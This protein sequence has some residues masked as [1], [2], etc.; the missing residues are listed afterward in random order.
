MTDK[1]LKQ[2]KSQLPEDERFDRAYSAYEGGIR[3]ISKTKD[4][5][6]F[7]YKVSFDTDGNA[8]IERF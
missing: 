2:I 5:R 1:Q 3:V 7:R 4:G 6:E 8:S